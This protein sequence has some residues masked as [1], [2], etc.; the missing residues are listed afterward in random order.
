MERKEEQSGLHLLS[1]LIDE[2]I[3]GGELL[4]NPKSQFQSQ[5]VEYIMAF[6]LSIYRK[7]IFR[8]LM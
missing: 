8:Y 5:Y 1:S 3:D 2:D 6:F 7:A 4:P